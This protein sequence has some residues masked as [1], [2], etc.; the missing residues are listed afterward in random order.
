[1]ARTDM[2]GRPLVRRDPIIGDDG[3]VLV[4]P[5]P[6]GHLTDAD[7]AASG[8]KLR[9]PRSPTMSE[10][11]VAVLPLAVELAEDEVAKLLGLIAMPNADVKRYG[12]AGLEELW[13][14][15]AALGDEILDAPM[16]QV[17]ELAVVAGECVTE[18][19][20]VKVRERLGE[21]LAAIARL[22]GMKV[23]P[24]TETGSETSL[25]PAST[26][27]PTSSTDSPAPTDGENEEPSTEPVS[28]ASEPS[29]TG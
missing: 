29:L 10:Q 7:W 13:D 5:D 9:E 2:L 22:F 4:G 1:V 25:T 23:E 17:I 18:T 20:Q 12:K 28:V 27:S 6:L 11:V 3:Q 15:A 24:K 16:D 21:R 14:Q 26:M 19:Y 8:N